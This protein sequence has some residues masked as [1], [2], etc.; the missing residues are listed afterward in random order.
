MF[1]TIDRKMTQKFKEGQC[2][3]DLKLRDFMTLRKKEGMLDGRMNAQ[4]WARMETR[5]TREVKYV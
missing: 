4:V 5:G 1:L 3:T 2:Q